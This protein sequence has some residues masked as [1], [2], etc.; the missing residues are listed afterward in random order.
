MYKLTGGSSLL[1]VN[2]IL[3]KA[4][5]K[6]KMKIADLGCG[7]SGYFVFPAAIMVGKEGKIYAVDIMRTALQAIE[8]KKRQEN[9]SNIE[10]VWSNL[11]IYNATKIESSSLDMAFLINTLYQTR[12][13]KEILLES[14]RLLKKGAKLVVVDWKNVSAPFGPPVEE[15]VNIANLKQVA[16]KLALNFEEEFFAGQFHA[17]LLFTKA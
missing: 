14:V 7:G 1:D 13:R 4:E 12:K 6:E 16:K 9:I 15:R 11:E 17:G 10:T 3:T 8:R 5:V 2:L